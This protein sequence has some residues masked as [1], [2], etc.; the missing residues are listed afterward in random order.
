MTEIELK[1]SRQKLGLT[2]AAMGEAINLTRE[3]I[4]LME[5]GRKPIDRRTE[6]AVRF[7]LHEHSQEKPS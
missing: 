1:E 4:G 6:L 5:R 2:Q 7:L 3:M